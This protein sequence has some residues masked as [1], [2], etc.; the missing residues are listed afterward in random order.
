MPKVSLE[1]IFHY[2]APQDLAQSECACTRWQAILGD[3]NTPFWTTRCLTLNPQGIEE[4]TARLQTGARLEA[5]A[6]VRAD[7]KLKERARAKLDLNEVEEEEAEGKAEAELNLN[8]EAARTLIVPV[9]INLKALAR[10]LLGDLFVV[11]NQYIISY[12]TGDSHKVSVSVKVISADSQRECT[13]LHPRGQCND[14]FKG[15]WQD[16]YSGIRDF[17]K[18]LPLRLFINR[19]GSFKNTGEKVRLCSHKKFAVLTCCFQPLHPSED[20]HKIEAHNFQEEILGRIHKSSTF[21][22]EEALATEQANPSQN[23]WTD[24]D[25]LFADIVDPSKES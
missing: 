9:V 18:T 8:L 1:K 10:P 2:L 3:D 25:K 20:H 11:P 21:F 14:N 5:E 15:T 6:K 22:T 17:P 16:N 4:A 24:L 13:R 12:K 19:D 7:A 23:T